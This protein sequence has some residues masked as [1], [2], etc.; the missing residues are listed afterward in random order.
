MST[1]QL[2]IKSSVSRTV[3]TLLGMVVVFYMMPFLVHNIGDKWYGIWTII[4]GLAGYYYLA[5]MGFASAVTRYVT[6]YI[7]KREYENAN[8]NINT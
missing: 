3:V 6:L 2:L 4:S 5:D 8:V 7:A 1:V